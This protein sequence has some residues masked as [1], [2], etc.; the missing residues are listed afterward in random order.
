MVWTQSE[1]TEL[2]CCDGYDNE[3]MNEQLPSAE[4]AVELAIDLA[5]IAGRLSVPAGPA[6]GGFVDRAVHVRDG[7]PHLAARLGADEDAA[8]TTMR[9]AAGARVDAR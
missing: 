5:D 3:L 1:G 7:G 8:R 4:S 2:G 6:V 9:L